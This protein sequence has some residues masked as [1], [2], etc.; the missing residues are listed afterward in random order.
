MLCLLT[1]NVHHG[2]NGCVSTHVSFSQTR[3]ARNVWELAPLLPRQEL[4]NRVLD[5]QQLVSRM[6]HHA[7]NLH[8]FSSYAQNLRISSS[9]AQLL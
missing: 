9:Y 7:K 8:S 3:R 4:S 1:H 6:R 2:L 5:S